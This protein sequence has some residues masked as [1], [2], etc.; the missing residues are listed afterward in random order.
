MTLPA[1]QRRAGRPDGGDWG[2]KP[3]VLVTESASRG[4]S[5]CQAARDPQARGRTIAANQPVTSAT[6]GLLTGSQQNGGL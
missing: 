5:P 1:V 3:A 2:D 4:N 6:S